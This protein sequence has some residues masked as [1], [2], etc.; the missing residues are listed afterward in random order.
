M[1]WEASPD[2]VFEPVR[3]G[4]EARGPRLRRRAAEADAGMRTRGACRKRSADSL[5]LEESVGKRAGVAFQ[6]SD[7]AVTD[8]R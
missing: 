8:N 4:G 6:T 1:A 2:V 3:T 5:L 7:L